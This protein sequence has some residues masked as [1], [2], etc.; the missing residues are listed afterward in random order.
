MQR[1]RDSSGLNWN[2]HFTTGLVP[3]LAVPEDSAGLPAAGEG[4][5]ED[6]AEGMS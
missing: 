5:D 1:R 2:P 6:E 3:L 4:E